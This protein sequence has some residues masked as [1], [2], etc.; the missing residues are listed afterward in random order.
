MDIDRS[1]RPLRHRR[2]KRSAEVQSLDEDLAVRESATL[3]E[4]L[5]FRNWR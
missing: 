2:A 1:P 4:S 3:E 5:W